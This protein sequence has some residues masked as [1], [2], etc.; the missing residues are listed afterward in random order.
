[1]T[2]K[3]GVLYGI[4]SKF[5]GYHS[6]EEE[7]PTGQSKALNKY[8]FVDHPEL[9]RN[10]FA[11]HRLPQREGNMNGRLIK[12]E[13][14][15]LEHEASDKEVNSDLESTASSKPMMKKTTKADPDYASRNC[16]CCSK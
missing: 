9:Q 15:P 3:H 7:E 5:P 10:E 4:I 12:D 2:Q 13:D 16:P 1:M 14:E 8:G 6:S 11:L